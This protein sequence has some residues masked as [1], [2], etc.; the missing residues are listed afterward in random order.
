MGNSKKKKKKKKK[1]LKKGHN[2]RTTILMEKQKKKKKKN[3]PLE[4]HA[5]MSHVMRRPVLRFVHTSFNPTQVSTNLLISA[6]TMKYE[7][8]VG[9]GRGWVFISKKK[10]FGS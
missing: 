1:T 2:S 10:Y 9:G 5:Y 7:G 6:K 8:G 3:G 4:F